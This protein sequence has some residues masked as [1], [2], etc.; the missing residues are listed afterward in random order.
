MIITEDN[1]G[2]VTL[3]MDID[4]SIALQDI[5]KHQKSDFAKQLYKILAK[6]ER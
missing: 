5:M 4:E 6:K 3:V 2:N 1:H